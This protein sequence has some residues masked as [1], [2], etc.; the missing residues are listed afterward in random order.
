MAH[1]CPR[2]EAEFDALITIDQGFEYQQK[3]KERRI[4]IL[5]IVS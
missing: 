5:L 1:S 2:A 4:A 3:L